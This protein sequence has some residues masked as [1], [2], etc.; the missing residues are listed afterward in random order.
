MAAAFDPNTAHLLEEIEFELAVSSIQGL[1][2]RSEEAENVECAL[3]KKGLSWMSCWVRLLQNREPRDSKKRDCMREQR[4][5]SVMFLKRGRAS[6]S[7]SKTPI[8]PIK[9][10]KGF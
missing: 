10:W 7:V 5:G 3:I 2:K 4:R 8:D 6:M 9:Y 1:I